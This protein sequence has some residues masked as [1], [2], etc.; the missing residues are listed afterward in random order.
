MGQ[1]AVLKGETNY[2]KRL[3]GNA[4]TRFADSIDQLVFSWVMYEV[5]GSA[6][7]SALFLFFNFLPTIL[8]QP[9]IGVLVERMRKK[10]VI[11]ICDIGRA[12]IVAGTLFA[13]LMGFLNGTL[14][15]ALTLLISTLEAFNLPANTAFLPFLLKKEKYG[16][17]I[18][19]TTGV[20]RIAELAGTGLGGMA[21]AIIGVSGALLLDL[22]GF[23]LSAI[24]TMMIRGHEEIEKVKLTLREYKTQFVDGI[25]L[26]RSLKTVC[27]FIALVCF[28][29]FCLSPLNS[30]QSA[31]VVDSLHFGAEMLSLMG[32]ALTLGLS[33][34]AAASPRFSRS[35]PVAKIILCSGIIQALSSLSFWAIP[36]AGHSTVRGLLIMLAAFIFGVSGG[37]IS[38]II[39]TRMVSDIPQSHLARLSGI[40]SAVG[41]ATVPLGALICSGL[42]MVVSVPLIFLLF[43]VLMLVVY[44]IVYKIK[45][46]NDA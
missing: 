36:F 16:A 4:L 14:L 25:R 18:A 45:I 5:T 26:L 11:I 6:T 22:A 20:A 21:I 46:L 15:I 13:Y 34:G 28:V 1:Y 7:M 17:G 44:I 38:V 19:L 3:F 40:Y 35:I 9:F 2:F 23:L 37:I 43:A 32:I 33:L 24:I 31:Y 30:F 12:V 41:T 29:N 27:V 42:A 10:Y 39:N 8:I